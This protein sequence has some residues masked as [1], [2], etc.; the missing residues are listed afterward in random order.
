MARVSVF[1]LMRRSEENMGAVN[2]KVKALVMELI[3]Q[4]YHEGIEV[5]I[6]SGYRSAAEQNRLYAQGRTAPGNIVTNARAGQSVHNYGYAVDYVIVSEDG[7][8]AIWSVTDEWRRVAAIA[9]ELGFQWGGDWTSFKDYPHIDIGG[10]SWQQLASGKRPKVPAVPERN[11]LG[12]GDSG[13]RVEALQKYLNMVGIKCGIDG[14]YGPATEAAVKE[15]QRKRALTVDGFYGPGSLA[16][17]NEALDELK[18]P[19]P[20]VKT[21]AK[22]EPEVEKEEQYQKDAQPSP[23]FKEAHEWVTEKKISDGTYP[24]RP[25]TREELW[26]MLYRIHS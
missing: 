17:M 7:N 9:K 13:G 18:A 19:A 11:Y 22:E 20:E 2:G 6:T 14:D 5:Q 24:K 4:A 12:I 15:F 16:E 10:L 8:Q 23:R 1:E 3:K 26:A 21:A 25:V